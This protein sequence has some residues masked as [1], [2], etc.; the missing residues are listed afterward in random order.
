MIRSVAAR[1]LRT[2][3][4]PKFAVKAA[5]A[6]VASVR[7]AATYTKMLDKVL[8]LNVHEKVKVVERSS[9]DSLYDDP[10]KLRSKHGHNVCR[11]AFHA[12]QLH[13]IDF[14]MD[15]CRKA[16]Y[17]MNIPCTGA[18]TMPKQIRRWTVLKSPFVHKSSMEVF[19]RRTHKRV[20]FVRD[21]DPEVVQKW[22]DYICENIPVGV[23][24]KYW[25]NEYEPLD[26][27][28]RIEN[29]LL[30]GDTKDVDAKS[31]ATTTYLQNVVQRGRR[32]LW[33]TYKDLPVFGRSDIAQ[34]ATD[35]ASQLKAN[36]RA[37]IEEVT[38]AT[39]LATRPPKHVKKDESKSVKTED[40]PEKPTPA[41]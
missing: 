33:T 9:T 26:I 16:A 17:H 24:M 20:L 28:K 30:T 23:G 5:A 3:V 40:T 39:L 10:I 38:R 21:A 2:G 18:V 41:A 1:A 14:Y 6:Q 27:G 4:Q 11:V 19:E 8:G 34:L 37:N 22:L 12:F 25:L 36:P 13:R 31:I 35:V 7:Y 15:F 29:A 32:R